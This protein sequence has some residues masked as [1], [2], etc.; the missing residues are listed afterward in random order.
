MNTRQDLIIATI[1]TAIPAAVGAFLPGSDAAPAAPP[2]PGNA[3]PAEPPRAPDAEFSS[4]FD[5]DDEDSPASARPG[6]A[7][8]QPAPHT[9]R[10]NAASITS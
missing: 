4:V 9:P 2:P 10:P 1:R 3:A 8:P 5:R 6:P 7:P